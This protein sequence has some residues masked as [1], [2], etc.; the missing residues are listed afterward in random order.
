MVFCGQFRGSN[1]GRTPAND[2][3]LKA[4]IKSKGPDALQPFK[5]AD[6]D[7]LFISP[8]DNQPFVILYEKLAA[9]SGVPG[10]PTPGEGTPGSSG[11]APSALGGQPVVAYEASGVAG[12]RLVASALGAVDEVDEK[13]FRELVPSAK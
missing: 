13:K 6:V 5:V 7:A 1:Q 3:E 4:F 9:S 10:M 8:R 11:S 2:E 12:K